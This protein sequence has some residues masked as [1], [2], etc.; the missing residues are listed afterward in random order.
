MR[1]IRR[2]ILT[3]VLWSVA[4]VLAFMF[5][6]WIW[7]TWHDDWSG[8]NAS[9]TISDGV[10]NIAVV[11]IIGDIIPYALTDQNESGS[12]SH[13]YTNSDDVLSTLRMAEDDQNIKG[14][15]VR[16]DSSGGSPVASEIISNGFKRSLLPVVAL[17]REIGTSGAYLAA[18]GA[19]TI[20]ASPFS[21][22]G[23]IGITM[24]YLENTAKNAK[25]GLQYI[26]LASAQ[27]KDYGDPDKSLTYA[28]R[29]L[30][31]RDLKI[32]HEQFVKEVA[33][34][35]NLP[36]E[37]VAKL[38]DGSS[39]PGS[40]ALENKLIDALGDQETA[41]DWLAEELGISPKKVVFCE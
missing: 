26:P 11:P 41:R 31:E 34:N 24:S 8:Y 36:I 29:I 18:T 32:Y 30:L 21:D 6:L 23:S 27:F 3:I 12:E 19:N 7:G 28:E 37:Q 5:G 20:I 2:E 1:T 13:S 25:D 9:L 35:R 40:L 10:C 38:A 39:M 22:I 4:I 17:I 15:L 33:E 16:I 14:I